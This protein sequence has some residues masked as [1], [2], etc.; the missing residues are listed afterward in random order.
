MDTIPA[1]PGAGVQGLPV[2]LAAVTAIR[3]GERV[4]RRGRALFFV[5]AKMVDDQ[6]HRGRAH[7]CAG[8]PLFRV[9]SGQLSQ[10]D[11]SQWRQVMLDRVPDA[12]GRNI[13]ILVPVNV[14]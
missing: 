10:D 14:S 3:G 9:E 4:D 8:S 12:P 1:K 7:H 6:H 11:G 2:Q 5:H 13:F